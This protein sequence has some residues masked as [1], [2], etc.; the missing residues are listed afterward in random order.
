MKEIFGRPHMSEKRFFD[1]KN[2]FSEKIVLFTKEFYCDN[3]EKL[4]IRNYR[5]R[6]RIFFEGFG[7][8]ELKKIF[9]EKKIV[10]RERHN[11]PVLAI[12]SDVVWIMNK[13]IDIISNGI[14]LYKKKYFIYILGDM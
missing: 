8:K 13:D 7:H 2:I 5:T 10:S 6:D 9:S 1:V 12:D 11:I 4:I 14:G 3:V